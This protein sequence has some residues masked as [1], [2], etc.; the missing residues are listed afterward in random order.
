M[1]RWDYKTLYRTRGAKGVLGG[2]RAEDWSQDISAMLP[3]LGTDGW[4]LVAVVPRSATGGETW[5]GLT[6]EEVWVFKRPAP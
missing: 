1:Q 6:D 4:E 2:F 5:A 3:Q